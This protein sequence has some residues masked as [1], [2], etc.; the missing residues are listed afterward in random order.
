MSG[1]AAEEERERHGRHRAPPA[2]WRGVF[3]RRRANCG[4]WCAAQAPH[5]GPLPQ[6]GARVCE[7]RFWA[8]AGRGR[9]G[10]CGDVRGSVLS[11]LRG[12]GIAL[13]LDHMAYAMGYCLSPLRDW[14]VGGL[15]HGRAARGGS[16]SS[17]DA[18]SPAWGRDRGSSGRRAPR[19]QSMAWFLASFAREAKRSWERYWWVSGRS[20]SS[21]AS[22]ASLKTRSFW[23]L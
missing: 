11:P 14:G 3:V 2:H 4:G 12:L 6:A 15:G 22:L 5:P 10:V 7:I 8:L 13:R 21:T 20:K 9:K 18:P 16:G 1:D 19:S 17:L 23:K